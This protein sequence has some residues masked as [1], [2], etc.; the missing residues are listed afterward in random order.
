[1][2]S[3]NYGSIKSM[4]S[5]QILFFKYLRLDR[6]GLCHDEGQP[7]LLTVSLRPQPETAE[8][9]PRGQCT[10]H[11]QKPILNSPVHPEGIICYIRYVWAPTGRDSP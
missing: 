9:N 3:P 7:W 2:L 11:A 10:E 1:M 6:G 8:K 4:L 5:N